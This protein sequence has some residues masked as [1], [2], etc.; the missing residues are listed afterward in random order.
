MPV[1]VFSFEKSTISVDVR[2]DFVVEPG[3]T[4]IIG[5][6]G[7]SI[8]KYVSITN[9]T[10]KVVN[11]ELTTEDLVG[12][13]NPNQP[14][15]LLGSETGPYSL[16]DFIK[17]EINNFSLAFGEKIRIPVTISIPVNIE[18]RG[19]YGALIISNR[20]DALSPDQS[21][22]TASTTKIIS[23]IGS[24]FLVKIKGEG[25]EA[26]SVTDFKLIG[27]HKLFYSN[28]PEGF[29]IAFKNTGT[30]HLVPYG[31]I[32]VKNMF[33]KVVGDIPVDAYFALPNST[34]YRD[35]DWAQGFSFGR[36]TA[37]LSLFKGYGN[38]YANAQISFWVLPWK[39][40]LGVFTGI[41]LLVFIFY[42]IGTR[43]ELK[44]KK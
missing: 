16:K 33:G 18:P 15:T 42:Y 37:S 8:T 38:E 19:Y 28:R 23:R 26:G 11:F 36:Y 4:E 39:L 27:P 2:N 13:D 5:N 41:L 32:K 6:P 25:T 44:K 21:A 29:E 43:F 34:R 14:V 12:T 3:K 24:L 1:A 31:R 35:V 30:V 40:L 7:E 20:P 17:P 22:D 9:R 10:K